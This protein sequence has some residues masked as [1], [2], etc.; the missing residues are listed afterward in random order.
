MFLCRHPNDDAGRL[1]HGGCLRPFLQRERV[2]AF[3]GN[4]GGN[5]ACTWKFNDNFG[6]NCARNHPGMRCNVRLA[7]RL[8]DV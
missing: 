6:I 2:Y 8:L 7:Q 1:E 5:R 3:I 4:D